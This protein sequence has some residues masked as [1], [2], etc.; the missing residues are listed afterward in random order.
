MFCVALCYLC[1]LLLFAFVVGGYAILGV[2]WGC[3]VQLR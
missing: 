3:C 2:L 1:L